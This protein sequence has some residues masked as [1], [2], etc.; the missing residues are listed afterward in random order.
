MVKVSTN[1]PMEVTIKVTLSVVW[2][3]AM[4]NG[5]T[6]MGQFMRVSLQKTLKMDTVG[7]HTN[8]VKVLKVFSRK[9]TNTKEYWLI[10]TRIESG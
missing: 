9:V 1:G 5:Y 4:E 6:I 2:D 7:R 10:R 3:K 8:R